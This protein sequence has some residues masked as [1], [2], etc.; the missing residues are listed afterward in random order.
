MCHTDLCSHGADSY[1][2]RCTEKAIVA[3]R[4]KR[5]ELALSY[6]RSRKLSEDLLRQR[7]GSIETLQSTLIRVEA[8]AG[9]IQVHHLL[10]EVLRA[11]SNVL[12][13]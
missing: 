10:V 8:A 3:L 11:F 7:L 6:I 13:R 4:Q 5:K 12:I 1:C 2:V 9:D